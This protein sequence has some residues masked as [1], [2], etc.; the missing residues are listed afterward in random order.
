LEDLQVE[1]EQAAK[2][3]DRYTYSD[4][5]Q[6]LS[7]PKGRGAIIFLLG[8]SFVVFGARLKLYGERI[9]DFYHALAYW[10]GYIFCVV[11]GLAMVLVLFGFAGQWLYPSN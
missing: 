9:W 8:I 10:G 4:P 7:H 2:G 6:I 5:I 11:G 1:D 3:E